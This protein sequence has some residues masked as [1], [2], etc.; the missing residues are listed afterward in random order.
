MQ[1]S[2]PLEKLL[3]N[4]WEKKIVKNKKFMGKWNIF[5][6]LSSKFFGL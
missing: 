6:L 4:S 5:L 3:K 1:T 2:N